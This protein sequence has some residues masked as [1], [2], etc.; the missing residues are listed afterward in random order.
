MGPDL[1]DVGARRGA[2]RLRQVLLEPGSAKPRD[3]SGYFAFLIVQAA[4]RD[5]R[6][7]RGLRVNEDTFTLQI[8]DS[9]NRLHSFPKDELVD[10]KRRT[11]ASV[12]PSYASVLSASDI[13]DL[14]AFLAGLRGD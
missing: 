6:L 13:D 7:V 10:L 8:R 14:I 5:G 4:T 11:G 1:T 12:M 9:E 3:G 2:A